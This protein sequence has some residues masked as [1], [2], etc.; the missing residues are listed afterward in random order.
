VKDVV[1]DIMPVK[2]VNESGYDLKMNS[3]VVVVRTEK[4]GFDFLQ[5]GKLAEIQAISF[6]L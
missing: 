6:R 1:Y 5:Q 2:E 4:T 3:H